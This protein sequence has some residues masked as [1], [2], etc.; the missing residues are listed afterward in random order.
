MIASKIEI[1]PQPRPI[2]GVWTSVLK[3]VLIASEIQKWPLP[4][5]NFES[6]YLKGIEFWFK[7]QK[8]DIT[9]DHGRQWETTGDHGGQFPRTDFGPGTHNVHLYQRRQDP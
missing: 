3:K 6:W 1:R 5:P 9:G 4:L 8:R 7:Q 2:F